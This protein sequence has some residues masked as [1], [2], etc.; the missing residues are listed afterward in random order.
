M[1]LEVH[2]YQVLVWPIVNV[3]QWGLDAKV[4]NLVPVPAPPTYHVSNTKYIKLNF[5]LN[6]NKYYVQ[7]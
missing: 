5:V 3:V 2:V 7:K 6:L 4:L 1:Y